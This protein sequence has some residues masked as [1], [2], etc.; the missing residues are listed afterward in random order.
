[1]ISSIRVWLIAIVTS[2]VATG[3]AWASTHTGFGHFRGSD[4]LAVATSLGAISW[5]GGRKTTRATLEDMLLRADCLIWQAEVAV[6]GD[7]WTWAIKVHPSTLAKTIFGPSELPTDGVGF[8]GGL[9]VPEMD[10]M[11]RRCREA[12]REGRPGYE[13]TFRIIR[14]AGTLWVRE[15]VTI[16]QIAEGK[17]DLVGVVT[18]ITRQHEAEVAR[19]ATGG[20]LNQLLDHANCIVWEA[21]VSSDDRDQFSWEWFV[22]KSNL[23]RRVAGDGTPDLP[24][25]PWGMMVV[26]EYEEIQIRSRAAMKSGQPSYEQEFHVIVDSEL[27]TMH[28]QVT[29]TVL[30][31]NKW[32]L[33]GVVIDLTDQRRLEEIQRKNAPRLEQVMERADCMVWSGRVKRLPDGGLDWDVFVTPSRLYRRIFGREPSNGEPSSFDWG[34]LQVPEFDRM[35]ATCR[36]ALDSGAPGYEQSFHVITPRGEVWLTEQVSISPA[37]K[38]QWDLAGIITD[39]TARHEAEEARRTSDAQLAQILEMADCMVWRA[40]VAQGPGGELVWS[41]FTPRSVLYRRLFGDKA[42]GNA[43]DWRGLNVPERE[44]MDRRAT[45]AIRSGASRYEQEFR[46]V[47]F[48]N[49]VWLR[50]VVT[51]TPL[52]PGKL[53]LVGVITD[54]TAQREAQEGR[55]TSE[56]QV[57]QIL[58]SSDCLLWQA[59]LFEITPGE[60]RWVQFIP[61]S[62]LYRELFGSDAGENAALRWP[63]VVDDAT[64][65]EID[66]RATRAILDGAPG[67]EQEFRAQRGNRVFWLHEQ[68]S[69]YKVRAGEW[70]LSGVI[71]DVTAR[72]GAELA[73][74]ASEARYRSLFRHS[75]VAI[76]ETDFSAV[77]EWLD[78]LRDEGMQDLDAWLDADPARIAEGVRRAQVSDCNETALVKLRVGSVEEFR[79]RGLALAAGEGLRFFR[80]TLIAIWQGRNTVEDLIDLPDL[81][82]V[83][84]YMNVRWWTN[85]GKAGLDLSQSV[86]VL[87]DLTDLKKAEDQLAAEKERLAVTLRAMGEGVITTDVDG[88]IQFMNPAASALTQWDGTAIGQPVSAICRL[89]N[90]RAGTPVEVPVAGVV[91]TGVVADLPKQTRLQPRSGPPKLVEGCCAPIHSSERQVIGTVM[92]IRDVTEQDRLE[93]ELVRASRLESVGV[94]AGGIAHDFNN[95]L[96]AVMGNLALAQLDVPMGSPAATQLASAERAALRARDLTQQLLTFSKGGEPVRTTV[97]LANVVREMTTFSLHGSPVTAAFDFPD[98]LWPADADKGQ[99]GRV[100]QNLV[101]NSMQ[102]MPDGGTVRV[103]MRNETIAPPGRPGLAPGDYCR[104]SVSDSGTGIR[105]EHLSRIFDPYFTTKPNGSG[106]GLAAVYSIVKKH[107]GHVEVESQVGSGATFRIWLPAVRERKPPS[108]PPLKV[109]DKPLRG[110]VLFMDDEQIIRQMATLMM[111]R[112]G[113]EVECANDGAEAVSIYQ[114]AMGAGSPFD[115][116]IM[117]LT[118]PGGMGGLEAVRRLREIDPNVRAIVS[119]GYSSDPVLANPRE[120][121]FCGVLA[122]PYQLDDFTRVIRATLAMT[123]QVVG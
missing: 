115:L 96:T 90:N 11:N 71:T 18:D 113:L 42:T 83:R 46:V 26:P 108:T 122:K 104:I 50:E 6:E 57:E 5:L 34:A 19:L 98:E 27:R 85:L 107:Q 70:R 36:A 109:K 103:S 48:R 24:H 101:I 23:Y 79:S 52:E 54:I 60:M 3:L 120:H 94:L 7:N 82:G 119:S 65:D 51:I 84:H 29:I 74:Q 93:Q 121:G 15:R 110:R 68:V 14:D 89:E 39:I 56:A 106:L 10:D 88:R 49:V 63:E 17:Y 118:V 12:M 44:E 99:I 41:I 105:P 64:N 117:D 123:P 97:Q 114:K 87:E 59:R 116:V 76:V 66:A 21:K 77:G 92:V 78:T 35:R 102:A 2:G 28:E 67:Y 1:M 95:I 75:P 73:L 69:I 81:E 33:K 40:N 9:H 55:R 72:R 25:M 100:V 38:D 112:F 20:Q 91:Q 37:G 32:L 86:I 45:S 61:K 47:Q 30:G 111:G 13:Q 58:A 62:R 53:Q 80:S 4:I 22:P 43:L 8:W 16:Q 31:P